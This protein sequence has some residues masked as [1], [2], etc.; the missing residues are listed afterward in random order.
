MDRSIR[1]V[2]DI[3]NPLDHPVD[4]IVY[5]DGTTIC[6]EIEAVYADAV[7]DLENRYDRTTIRYS[8]SAFMRMKLREVFARSKSALVFESHSDAQQFLEAVR[9][10]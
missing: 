2:E 4:A 10:S 8:A 5:Y 3:C 6:P 7:Q 1:W 9:K